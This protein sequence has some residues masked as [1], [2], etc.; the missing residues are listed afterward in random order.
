MFLF[1]YYFIFI[2]YLLDI[3]FI[4][5]LNVISFPNF[6]QKI[7]Y[8]FPPPSAPQPTYSHSWPW[9]SPILGHR[10]FTGPR[11]SLPLMTD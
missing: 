10:T 4:Y 7:P 3:F 2:R 6:S 9:H 11:A 8:I 5:I 1:S